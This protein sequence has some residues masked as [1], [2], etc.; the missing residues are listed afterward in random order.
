MIESII[1]SS[2]INSLCLAIV[3]IKSASKV[4]KNKSNLIDLLYSYK[5]VSFNSFFLQNFQMNKFFHPL[6]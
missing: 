5:S 2:S 6:H 3:L 1:F 4:F